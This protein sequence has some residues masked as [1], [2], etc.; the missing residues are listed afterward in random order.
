MTLSKMLALVFL[1]SSV[2]LGQQGQPCSLKAPLWGCIL[3]T[4]NGVP[5]YY[6]DAVDD[7]VEITTPGPLFDAFQYQ[8]P[9]FVRRYY[10][11]IKH[12]DTSTWGPNSLNPPATR[13]GDGR[14]YFPR[15]AE[16]HLTPYA[17]GITTGCSHR[18]TI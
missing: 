17:N 1:G 16:F 6:N 18:L 5:I 9:E 7:G 11:L 15:A 10:N 8:C 4:Y 12:T 14:N 13:H 2:C 3:D